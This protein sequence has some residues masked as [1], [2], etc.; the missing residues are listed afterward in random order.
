M[1][2]RPPLIFAALALSGMAAAASV[3]PQAIVA[4]ARASV[5]AALGSRYSAVDLVETTRPA[6]AAPEDVTLHAMPV[7]GR[8]PRQRFTVDVQ[9]VRRGLVVG[10]ATVGFALHVANEGWVYARDARDHEDVAS[11]AIE[12]GAVDAARVAP[13]SPDDLTGMRLR[14]N[15]HAGQ[16][17]SLAD[18]ERVPDVDNRQTIRLRA[19]F[20]E[21]TVESA[22][23]ALRAGNRG[24]V[25][26]VQIDGASAPVKATVV[27]RGV[28][29]LVQ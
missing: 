15:V 16:A 6:A 13:A 21:I 28:A 11:L 8:F 24:D 10:K 12:R 18:F 9:F 29:E 3:P 20:G 1:I 4:S 26:T 25:V 7:V 22:G 27:D 17:V 23:L 2:L 14:R 19:A 5:E